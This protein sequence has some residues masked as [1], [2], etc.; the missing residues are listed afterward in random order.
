[1]RVK[2]S[3]ALVSI[4]FVLAI[5]PAAALDPKARIGQYGHTA[6]R[7]QEGAFESAP[8]VITQTTDGYLWIGTSS[9]L[10]RYDGVRF[11]PWTPPAGQS[12]PGS[13]IY[14]LLASH[15]GTLW[16]GSS[17]HLL[18]WKDSNLKQ[19]VRG[20]INTIVEDHKGRIWAARSRVQDSEG[21]LC[22]VSGDHA[23]CMGGDER[24]RLPYAGPLVEDV[25]GNLWVGAS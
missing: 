3:I 23:G 7:V 1:M 8:H 4:T 10:V 24:M 15:D 5:R 18:S 17:T 9:G 2:N 13:G 21:G 22:H 20:R 11:A 16:I 14:S 6:W 25:Q 12:L 19:Y